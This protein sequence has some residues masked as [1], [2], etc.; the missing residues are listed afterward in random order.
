MFVYYETENNGTAI[1]N[2]TL[3]VSFEQEVV[4]DTTGVN[5]IGHRAVY[6]FEGLIAPYSG[7][8]MPIDDCMRLETI[9]ASQG[10]DAGFARLG[11]I[12]RTLLTP[13]GKLRVGAG[14]NFAGCN[15]SLYEKNGS[16]LLAADPNTN[17][18]TNGMAVYTDM[19]NG[20]KPK[21]VEVVF[22]TTSAIKIRFTIEVTTLL[23]MLPYSLENMDG[24][25]P[26]KKGNVV[27]N[28][29]TC[30]EEMDVNFFTTRKYRGTIKT[31]NPTISAHRA[32]NWFNPPLEKGFVRTM[33]AYSEGED[34]TTLNYEVVDKQ[35]KIAAPYPARTIKGNYTVTTNKDGAPI[36]IHHITITLT[37]GPDCDCRN[38]NVLATDICFKRSRLARFRY[39]KSTP[40]VITNFSVSESFG[41]EEGAVAITATLSYQVTAPVGQDEDSAPWYSFLKK[42]NVSGIND[43]YMTQDN[44]TAPLAKGSSMLWSSVMSVGSPWS[45]MP[46]LTDAN[47]NVLATYDPLD[48]RM[49]DAFGYNTT[50]DKYKQTGV[51][52]DTSEAK[53]GSRAATTVFLKALA[54]EPCYETKAA[55]LKYN[56][57][58]EIPTDSVTAVAQ[59]P[60]VR[61]ASTLMTTVELPP[62]SIVTASAV[63]AAPLSYKSRVT[64]E[65]QR[66]RA[67]LPTATKSY[68]QKNARTTTLVDLAQPVLI[69]HVVIEASRVGA[70]PVFPDK[71]KAVA[72]EYNASA[73]AL[74]DGNR[75]PNVGKTVAETAA[76][77]PFM[78]PI[79]D[80]ITMEDPI[81]DAIDS[82]WIYKG[83][84][85][86]D[87]A[88]SRPFENGDM[89]KLL[90]PGFL[91]DGSNALAYSDV[92][93][94]NQV[95]HVYA[96]ADQ[97]TNLVLG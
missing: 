55:F 10:P 75:S 48:N 54:S 56:G 95:N 61:V 12:K 17:A 96:A 49:P 9:T 1:L 42:A 88:V 60:V 32:R 50:D 45:E 80:S 39:L 83:I 13:R 82:R 79:C 28:R 81:R 5:L 53:A 15:F 64:Y 33:L 91:A 59:I 34:G 58:Q 84:A 38:L 7:K 67:A 14:R 18:N 97:P 94:G 4:Y 72:C 89:L 85:R 87:Y 22:A 40:Y 93:G 3:I 90:W 62:R 76:R 20:P 24:P 23:C 26:V 37:G 86:Y 46:D 68:A 66:T 36:P 27:S 57:S 63:V 11:V 52:N 71:Y 47:G 41:T 35:T 70:A 44:K 65:T 77:R 29:W 31:S 25:N 16:W 6:T 2:D 74:A 78:V 92:Y 8:T 51:A 43:Y 73:A 30:S 69:A 21:S 19:D